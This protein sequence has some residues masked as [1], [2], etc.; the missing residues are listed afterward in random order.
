MFIIIHLQI[1]L[2]VVFFA[3][4]GWPAVERYLERKVMVVKDQRNTGGIP[5]PS[6]TLEVRNP[7][8]GWRHREFSKIETIFKTLNLLKTA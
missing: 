2:L 7:Y 4:F 1:I 3:Y 6:I 8:S 5:A